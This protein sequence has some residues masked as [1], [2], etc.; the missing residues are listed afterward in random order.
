MHSQLGSNGVATDDQARKAF[1]ESM[2][3]SFTLV[4]AYRLDPDLV[5]AAGAFFYSTANRARIDSA[6][7]EFVIGT[8][9]L[10][11]ENQQ[12]GCIT[13]NSKDGTIG[14]VYARLGAIIGIYSF[15][16]GWLEASI[17]SIWQC[18]GPT[19]NCDVFI[20]TVPMM[21]AEEFEQFTTRPASIASKSLNKYKKCVVDDSA[22]MNE[23]VSIFPPM[24][25]DWRPF[26]SAKTGQ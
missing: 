7:P 18:L 1:L 2:Y 13:I 5:L 20:S 3:E 19:K 17:D 16:E 21:Y 22:V 14:A 8:I 9:K 6:T 24:E 25:D 10:I 23:L 26:V 11:L 4:D 15:K 12:T